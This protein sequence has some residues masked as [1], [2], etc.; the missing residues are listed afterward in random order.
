MKDTLGLSAVWDEI[1]NLGNSVLGEL[2]TVAAKLLFAGKEK[3][4]QA[5]D[6]FG[7]LVDDLTNHAGDAS[8]IVAA[9]I[10]A[11]KGIVGK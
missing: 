9:A 8:S 10:A 2:M 6:I 5:K 1:K 4:N 7:K 3:L 11:L